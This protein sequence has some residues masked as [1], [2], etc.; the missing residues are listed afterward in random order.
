MVVKVHPKVAALRILK[1]RLHDGLP[2]LS[3]LRE[4][5][6]NGLDPRAAMA[7]V[8]ELRTDGCIEVRSAAGNGEKK[9]VRKH[10][11]TEKGAELL[12]RYLASEPLGTRR[13]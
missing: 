7:A 10:F 6:K 8:G 13:S 1:A 5:R 2:Y 11:I 12:L 9:E 3:L 4:M